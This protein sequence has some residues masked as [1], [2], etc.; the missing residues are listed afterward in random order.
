MDAKDIAQLRR[1]EEYLN[2]SLEFA[3]RDDDLLLIFSALSAKGRF[4]VEAGLAGTVDKLLP[5]MA[6]LN[7]SFTLAMPIHH[8]VDFIKEF[9]IHFGRTWTDS[10]YAELL[11]AKR[12]KA[13]YIDM[14]DWW[15]TELRELRGYRKG[16]Y[17][18][19]ELE[20]NV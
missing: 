4:W 2:F 8:K 16:L 11:E 13:N 12:R 20:V 15:T 1:L 7:R 5:I 6:T 14:D 9:E 10:D 19:T 17:Q 18:L 3:S